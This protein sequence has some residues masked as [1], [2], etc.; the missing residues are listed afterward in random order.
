MGRNDDDLRILE[1]REKQL[2][3]GLTASSAEI[4]DD[5]MSESLTY[6][7]SQGIAETKRENLIGQQSGLFRHGHIERR[8]GETRV[9]GD[10]AVTNGLIDMVDLAHGSAQTLHLEQ[11]LIWIKEGGKWRLLSRSATK[12]GG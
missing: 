7:H 5:V 1:E 6:V 10:L 8:N 12:A 3:A 4:L 11:T 2:Y 9:Y